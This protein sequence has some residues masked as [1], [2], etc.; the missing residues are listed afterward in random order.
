MG[1]SWRAKTGSGA[2]GPTYGPALAR[3]NKVR[4]LRLP[5]RQMVHYRSD[6]E[7]TPIHLLT[8]AGQSVWSDQISRT[9]LD[10][11]ELADRISRQAVTGVTS[12]PTIFA[13]AIT[14]SSA[15]D[16][17]I[18]EMA[19][20][21]AS[22]DEIYAAL[23]TDDLQRACDELAGVFVATGGR[24]GFVS[25]E[26][27]PEL[28]Y[29]ADGTV[30]EAREWSKRIDRPNL[31]VKIPATTEGVGAIRRAIAEGISI[32]VTL[33]F[34]LDRYR[35]VM[36][37]YLAGLED[38]AASRGDISQIAGVASF[39]VSR[40]DTEIDK[41]LVALGSPE[42]LAL[43]GK[44]AVANAQIAYELF[45][46][47]FTGERWNAL[48]VRGARVQR[49]LWASTSTKN[50]EYRDTLY[51][52][53]LI[54]PHTVNTMPLE[55]I[56]AYQDHGGFPSPIGPEEISSAKAVL[57]AVGAQDVD[58]DDV[59]RVLAEEG[60][61]KFAKSFRDLYEDIASKASRM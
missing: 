27:S 11:G 22:V 38:L 9:M 21:A 18:A 6:M 56:D 46:Q 24:D 41:R 50:P 29:D 35:E 14:K 13:N 57:V 52:D 33:I 39:F 58:Y 60:V 3:Q 36:E 43:R 25:V 61:D 53:T 8:A 28:A 59:V 49:P 19:S 45:W 30:A 7:S 16:A 42:A 54:A 12:N 2:L 44:A 1:R 48:A 5:V 20:R 10:T 55:T 23:V 15:Y 32:N 26:V 37:S 31:L 4:E 40:V 17:Q 47:T 34:A 51:V